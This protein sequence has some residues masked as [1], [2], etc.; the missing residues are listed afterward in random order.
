MIIQLHFCIVKDFK[1]I[2]LLVMETLNTIKKITLTALFLLFNFATTLWGQGWTNTYSP[3]RQLRINAIHQLEDESYW[4]TGANLLTNDKT[5]LLRVDKDGVVVQGFDYDSISGGFS[6]STITPDRGMIIFGTGVHDPDFQHTRR[7]VA[8]RVDENGEKLWYKEVHVFENP[9]GTGQGNMAIDTTDDNGFICALNPHDTAFNQKRILLKRLDENGNILW[10]QH[11]YDSVPSA[12]VTSVLNSKDNGFIVGA[13]GFDSV[14][15]Y[16]SKIF[17]IDA[18]GNFLWEYVPSFPTAWVSGFVS[19]D[20]TK[21]NVHGTDTS[22]AISSPYLGQIDQNGNELW[23]QSYPPLSDSSS[24]GFLVELDDF[25]FAGIT[26]KSSGSIVENTRFSLAKIDTSGNILT[27][28]FLPTSNLSLDYNLLQGAFNKTIDQGF[29]FGGWVNHFSENTPCG[30]LIKT[31]STG[32]V[33]P[34]SI[35]GKAFYDRN[36]NCEID[37]DEEFLP[38]KFLSFSN[39]QDS[40]LVSTQSDGSYTLGLDNSIYNV[41]VVNTIAPYWEES[42]CNINTINLSG[43]IDTVVNFG[44]EPV[45]ELPYIVVDA[46]T[47]PRICVNNTY[48]IKYCNNGTAEFTGIVEIEVDELLEI[49][50]SSIPWSSINNNTLIF[51]QADELGIGECETIEIYYDVPCEMDLTGVA[52]CIDVSVISDSVLNVNPLWDESNLELSVEYEQG[53]DSIE[54]KLKNIGSGNMGNPENLIVIEDNVILE[55]N[56]IELSSQAEFN[57]K[58]PANGKT[59]RAFINQTAFNPYSKFAT[60][61]IEGATFDASQEISLGFANQFPNNG[62]HAFY[63]TFCDIVRNSYDPNQ[64]TVFPEGLLPGN[65]IKEN[66]NLEYMLEFQNTGN[67]VAYVVRIVDTLPPYVNPQTLVTGISSHPYTFKFLDYNVVEFLFEGIN[68]PDSASDESGSK[69]FVKF[70]IDQIPDNPVGTKIDNSVA[71][72]FDY[73]DPI[74]TN[75]ARVVIGEFKITDLETSISDNGESNIEIST[76]PNPFKEFVNFRVGGEIYESLELNLYDMSGRNISKQIVHNSNELRINAENLTQ[77]LYIFEIS[78]KGR[79]LGT[80]KI[81]AQ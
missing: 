34:N 67:D 22:Y 64:K 74:I 79:I 24:L 27:Q 68:L 58:V 36:E 46:F 7:R 66:M 55:L 73:N 44:F 80:G 2:K 43:N 59:W 76:Y 32:Q 65:F 39:S 10:E 29:I 71:I 41:S 60:K 70:K 61:F 40:F 14:E 4:V 57:F 13:S 3:D 47:R 48:Y 69:G 53:E 30:F 19:N 26:S 62:Y 1:K 54:F 28:K 37:Q 9:S 20:P 81:M 75:I 23:V 11:Y 42:D 15:E 5:R 35:S 77:S 56:P 25:T 12:F 6:Q 8:L 50:G 38:G 17:K 45:E 63:H 52:V 21:I 31:D 18:N 16:R 78:S 72:Y 49:T 33:Y 51:F